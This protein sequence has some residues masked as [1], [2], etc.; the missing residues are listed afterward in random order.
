MTWVYSSL[1]PSLPALKVKLARENQG[2]ELLSLS[3]RQVWLSLEV[4]FGAWGSQKETGD[5]D[6]GHFLAV[7]PW[8]G[9]CASLGRL[10]IAD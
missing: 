9:D 7:W 10:C 1:S 3:T 6:S 8:A 2:T 5:L 4:Q